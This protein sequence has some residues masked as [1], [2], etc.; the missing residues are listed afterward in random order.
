MKPLNLVK[1]GDVA[2][3][4][5]LNLSKVA[6]FTAELFW[7]S[8]HDLDAHALLATN[9]GDGAKVSAFEQV[10]S[11]YNCK[12]TN[13]QGCLNGNSDGSFSTPEGALTHGGDART[14]V[15][16]DV[17]EV[18][19]IDGAKMPSGVN[20][21]PIFVTI[22]PSKSAKFADV[23]SAGIRI[24]ND[25]GV[26]L[27]EYELSNQFGQF[28]AVQ[29]GSLLLGPSGWEFVEAGAGF[30]GDFNSILEYFS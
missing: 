14:G 20:E 8:E 28:D 5:S 7:D 27:G 4:L 21:I 25:Q 9:S 19:I 15:N 6:R 18:I 13:P 30:N 3:K 23:K 17:D 10:L 26:V 24:K 16:A 29:M 1:Q 11:T 22:H 2:P 12:K